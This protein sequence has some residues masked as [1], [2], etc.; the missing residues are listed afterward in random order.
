MAQQVCGDFGKEV[1]RS[2]VAVVESQSRVK[3]LGLSASGTGY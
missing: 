2:L 3:H 1:C